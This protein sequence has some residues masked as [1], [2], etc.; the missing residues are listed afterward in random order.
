MWRLPNKLSVY[1][2]RHTWGTNTFWGTPKKVLR[3]LRS[4]GQVLRIPRSHQGGVHVN[5]ATLKCY[6]VLNKNDNHLIL[7]K[8]PLV[9]V[10]KQITLRFQSLTFFD[11][12]WQCCNITENVLNLLDGYSSRCPSDRCTCRCLQRRQEREENRGHFPCGVSLH[13][14]IRRRVFCFCFFKLYINY[15]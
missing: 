1:S 8:S 3:V 6:T 14:K 5:K 2:P 4:G 7:K 9:K 10:R 12:C 11:N 15:V 13:P